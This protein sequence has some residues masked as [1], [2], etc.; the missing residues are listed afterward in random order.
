LRKDSGRVRAI[1]S[2][3]DER[4]DRLERMRA[5]ARLGGGAARIDKQHGAGKLTARERLDQIGRASCRERV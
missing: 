1:V 3:N 4:L 5:E 2:T